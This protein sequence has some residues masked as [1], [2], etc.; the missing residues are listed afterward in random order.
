[1]SGEKGRISSFSSCKK[2]RKGEKK[3]RVSKNQRAPVGPKD[4][5]AKVHSVLGANSK[6]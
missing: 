5:A 3:G 6:T 1:M 2:G 4:Q